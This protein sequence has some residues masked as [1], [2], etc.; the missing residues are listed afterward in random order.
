MRSTTNTNEGA[1]SVHYYVLLG[2][3]LVTA[4]I[5]LL[6]WR[7][8]RYVPRHACRS[9]LV[10]TGAGRCLALLSALI[11]RMHGYV[12]VSNKLRTF[13]T[14]F[15]ALYAPRGA[16]TLVRQRT[17][18]CDASFNGTTHLLGY[19]SA[20]QNRSHVLFVRSPC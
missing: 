15:P 12:Q 4:S 9:K 17:I 14:R 7:A 10:I 18:A 3:I 20:H 8:H 11:S 5:P 19:K 13:C 1:L 2:H 6:N 16:K